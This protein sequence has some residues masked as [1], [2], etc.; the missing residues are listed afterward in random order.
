MAFL[1]IDISAPPVTPFEPAPA[2]KP[3]DTATRKDFDD[4]LDRAC[5]SGDADENSA[6]PVDEGRRSSGSGTKTKSKSAD[7]REQTAKVD[8][9]RPANNDEK[10]PAVESA[11]E[12]N[13]TT[14]AVVATPAV[15]A[16]LLE[17]ADA[18]EE[19]HEKTTATAAGDEPLAETATKAAQGVD[20]VV[21]ADAAAELAP[22][23]VATD[24]EVTAPTAE[25]VKDA[26]SEVVA[27]PLVSHMRAK[28]H[29][30]AQLANTAHEPGVKAT[31]ESAVPTPAEPIHAAAGQLEVAPIAEGEAETPLESGD[32]HGETSTAQP[33]GANGVAESA[34]TPVVA[35]VVPTLPTASDMT[36][37]GST[38]EKSTD[39][40]ESTTADAATKN[41]ASP[42]IDP[43][44]NHP[45]RL[46]VT[47]NAYG[48]SS[49]V[50]S[51]GLT[52][53][54]R[55]RF[56]QRV[57]RAFQTIGD[58]GNPLRL[59][60]SPPELGSLR[61]EI[62]MNQG[63]MTARVEAETEAAR[64]VLLDN[65]PALRERLAQQDIKIARFDV[66]LFGQTS[67]G[68][69]Q[70]QDR[71]PA[72]DDGSAA[73]GSRRR[74]SGSGERAPVELGPL[75]PATLSD[76]RLNVII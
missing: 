51:G 58:S 44:P 72:R 46:P 68:L 43:S 21:A 18:S 39:R 10:Q 28:G 25:A 3:R 14:A 11:S 65:L 22:L 27:K 4:H 64:T 7:D 75:A 33:V 34:L 40:V 71:G 41:P 6:K 30:D 36:S 69:P 35:A 20:T 59:R 47:L 15:E 2:P 66:D 8:D 54:Q 42:S 56:V 24:S 73:S 74:P 62:T 45:P 26:E 67:G 53:V 32:T 23:E 63:Q 29:G 48:K 19:Q 76:G 60:L 9:S 17:T 49:D 13:T 52:E 55:V 16:A 38:S 31:A 5:R 1:N 61:L 12:A 57:A 50:E 70:N 37:G